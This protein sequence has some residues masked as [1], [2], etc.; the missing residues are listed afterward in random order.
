[1]GE[2][3]GTSPGVARLVEVQLDRVSCEIQDIRRS[4]TIDVGESQTAAVEEISA[5]ETGRLGHGDLR[6]EAAKPKIG[7]V[8]DLPVADANQIGQPIAGHVGQEDR[9]AA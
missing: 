3:A 4:G 9:L 6:P 8:A 2:S 7:P 5:V 1:M